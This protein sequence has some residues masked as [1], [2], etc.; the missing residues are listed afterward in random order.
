MAPTCDECGKEMSLEYEVVID[1]GKYQI[2]ACKKCGW[3]K[4]EIV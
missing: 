3:V 1:G 2:W 4:E